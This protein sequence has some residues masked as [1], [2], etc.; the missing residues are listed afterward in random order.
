M[1]TVFDFVLTGRRPY[2]NFTSTKNDE[3]KA[4][5]ALKTV[6]S[7]LTSENFINALHVYLFAWR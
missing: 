7:L 5:E 6:N 3:E 2:I 4:Y 1:L